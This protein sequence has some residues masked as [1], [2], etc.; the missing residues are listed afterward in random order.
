MKKLLVMLLAASTFIFT[1]CTKTGPPGPQGPQGP[2]G[3][4]GNANVIGSDPF[5]VSSWSKTGNTYYANFTSSDIT[6]AVVDRGIVS[7][8]KSYATSS[9]PE[10]SPLPDIN[11]KTST[12]YNF[13][14]NGFSIYVQNSDGSDPGF[15]GSV[16][17]RMVVVSPSQ[18]QA[19][20]GTNWKDYKQVM[21]VVNAAQ[22][23][24]AAK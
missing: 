24:A 18:R 4:Q 16:T 23:E 19:N 22:Q 12:V 14:D 20:P 6:P 17:F 7:V 11:G 1:G 3:P 10:W 13:F 5:T 2:T 8:F 21:G 15:P 9:G